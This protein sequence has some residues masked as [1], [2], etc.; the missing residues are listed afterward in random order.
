MFTLSPIEKSKGG[1]YEPLEA[2]KYDAVLH[3]IISLERQKY[4]YKGQPKVSP[5]IL[6]LFELPDVLRPA[7][8][9]KQLAALQNYELTLSTSEKGN[10]I[11]VV[12]ALEHKSFTEDELYN[13]INS[14][15]SMTG[16]LGKKCIVEVITKK[17]QKGELRNYMGG[18]L[19]LD[20]RA[21]RGRET[22]LKP[23]REPFIFTAAKPNIDI[24][25]NKLIGWT[26]DKIMSAVN[27]DEFPAE[28]HKAYRDVKEQEAAN[29]TNKLV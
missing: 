4:E 9:G 1:N 24:F 20:P 27:S 15:E 25:K 7:A 13:F 17:N 23:T 5:K 29:S 19:E 12:N 8:D 16:L 18:V 3:A 2:G 22:P 11:T 10:F 6:M 28:L 21:E 26:R 14:E